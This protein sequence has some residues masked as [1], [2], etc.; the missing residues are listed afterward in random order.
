MPSRTSVQI[1]GAD[2]ALWHRIRAEAK[3]RRLYPWQLWDRIAAEWLER[4]HVPEL[5][6]SPPPQREDSAAA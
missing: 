6:P 5:P 2:P 3:R 4:E 1:P